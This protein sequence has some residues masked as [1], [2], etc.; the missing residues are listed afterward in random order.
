MELTEVTEDQDGAQ[1]HANKK[2]WNIRTH[3]LQAISVVNNAQ[4]SSTHCF[5]EKTGDD[6][7]SGPEGVRHG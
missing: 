6:P 2:L 5:Y 7:T 3:I 1:S 4:L